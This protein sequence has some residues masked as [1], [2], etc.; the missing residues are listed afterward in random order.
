MQGVDREAFQVMLRTPILIVLVCLASPVAAQSNGW[1][2]TSFA[3]FKLGN[4]TLGQVADDLGPAKL[5]E[6]G[7]AGGYQAE[8]CYRT[9]AGV[10]SFL[11]GEMGGRGHRLLGFDISRDEATRP[12]AKFPAARAPRTL[13]LAGLRLG[14]SKAGFAHAVAANVRWEGNIGR[15]DFESTRTMTPAEMRRIYKDVHEAMRTGQLQNYFDVVVSVEGTFSDDQLIEFR[16]WKVE[17]F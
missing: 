9:P 2:F 10:V 4:V 6:S 14:Q 8:I 5:V 12:C 11:S 17:T 13:N 15:V 3:G 16:V 1:Q 7:D